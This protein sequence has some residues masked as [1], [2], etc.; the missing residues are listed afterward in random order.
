MLSRVLGNGLTNFALQLGL[1][2]ANATYCMSTIILGIDPGVADTGFGVI[3]I[4]PSGR[5]RCL[6]YG[7]IKTPAGTGLPE[8][9]ETIFFA[10]DALCKRYQ[11]L[12]LAIEKLFFSRNVTTA[13]SVSQARGVVLLASQLNKVPVREFTPPQVKQAV[14]AYGQADKAQVQKMV[15]LILGL[16]TIPKPDDAADALAIAICASALPLRL[17][18]DTHI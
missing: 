13:M 10:V 12:V 5:P 3:A 11:P 16:E 6:E 18:R 15:K 14:A 1:I 8:R 7:S 2:Y 9:L 17:L 4:E